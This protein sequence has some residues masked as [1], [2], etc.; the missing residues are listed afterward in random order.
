VVALV[1]D[2]LARSTRA[3]VFESRAL[4]KGPVAAVPLPLQPYGFHGFWEGPA[5]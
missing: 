5:A 4:A 1:Y 3:C 2:G